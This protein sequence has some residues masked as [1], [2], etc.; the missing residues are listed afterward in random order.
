MDINNPWGDRDPQEA[1]ALKCLVDAEAC[2]GE[3]MLNDSIDMYSMALELSVRVLDYFPQCTIAHY[4]AGLSSLRA[5]GDK[6][7]AMQKCE[8]LQSNESEDAHIL[9]K[10][11]KA[12]IDK[13]KAGR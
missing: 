4:F 2:L 6:K 1:E 8:L 10:R 5:N 3:A 9:A 11:L 12:E 13:N 7:F